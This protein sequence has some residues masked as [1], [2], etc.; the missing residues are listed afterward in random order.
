MTTDPFI[1]AF[2]DTVQDEGEFGDDPNDPGNWT[3]KKRGVGELKGTKYGISAASYPHLDIRNLTMEQAM[4]IYRRDFWVALRCHV[5]TAFDAP[6]AAKLFNL[7]VNCGVGRAAKML[8]RGLNILCADYP[9]RRLNPWRQKI[10]QLMAGKP[11]LVDGQ[12]GPITLE[13]MRTCPH[14]GAELM[15]LKGEAY[16]HYSQCDPL[17]RMGWLERLGR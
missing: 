13:I 17:Y 11:L 1:D 16:I 12:I 6:L 5:I 15:A 14:D 7:G 10:A 8:Q 9:A 2:T 3:G 4:E